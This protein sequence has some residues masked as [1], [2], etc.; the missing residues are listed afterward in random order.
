MKTQALKTLSYSGGLTLHA[1]PRRYQLDKL[2]TDRRP[3]DSRSVTFAYGHAI[4]EG[5]QSI[6]A[7]DTLEETIFKM[8]LIWD[9]DL[10]ESEPRTKKS[11]AMAVLA[12]YKFLDYY[13]HSDL[14]NY[15]VA[16]IKGKSATEL[17]FAINLP[18]GYRYRGFIDVVLAHKETGALKVLELKTTGFTNLNP[19]MYCNSSQ[20]L[21][22]AVVLDTLKD[23]NI[24]ASFDVEYLVYKS[25]KQEF[26]NFTFTKLFN[27]KVSWIQDTLK[28]CDHI[29]DYIE[30]NHFP[31]RGE[32]CYHFFREC[33]HLPYC[34]L[35]DKNLKLD[36]EAIKEDDTDYTIEL[37]LLDIIES[38]EK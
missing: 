10:L 36:L 11:F 9:Y 30:E 25:S 27:Q 17:S 24:G 22:Y 5:I 7:R 38:M 26:E 1:C 4:G 32:S 6:L 33:P 20:A 21:G 23:N 2:I 31:K 29:T 28:D 15:E 35:K 12:I 13:E 34:N 3:Q 18:E 14:A 16:T 37:N 19:A 8:F